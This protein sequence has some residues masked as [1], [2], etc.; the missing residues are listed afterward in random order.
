MISGYILQVPEDNTLFLL[1]C[2][3][4]CC[5]L[6]T[7]LEKQPVFNLSIPR[8]VHQSPP[9]FSFLFT[10]KNPEET[11]TDLWDFAS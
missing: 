8:E 9:S 11:I 2:C 6:S 4:C 3:G 10:F 5:F 7:R 1:Y